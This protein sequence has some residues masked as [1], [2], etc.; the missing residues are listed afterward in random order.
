MEV[1]HHDLRLEPD[2][3]VLSDQKVYTIKNA[4]LGVTLL[5]PNPP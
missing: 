1:V 4:G 3:V 2:G 5:V